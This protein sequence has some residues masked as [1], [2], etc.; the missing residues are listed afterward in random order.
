VTANEASVCVGALVGGGT[1]FG[2][3]EASR[4]MGNERRERITKR[5][6]AVGFLVLG[7]VVLVDQIPEL[8]RFALLGLLGGFAAMTIGLMAIHRAFGREPL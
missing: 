4:H 3:Y 6:K 2:V 5:V 8:G 7:V 1:S